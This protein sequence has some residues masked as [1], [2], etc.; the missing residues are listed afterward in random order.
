MRVPFAPPFLAD[1]PQLQFDDTGRPEH[2][3][4]RLRQW[5]ERLLLVRLGP[6]PR[7]CGLTRMCVRWGSP[8]ANET[9]ADVEEEM[10]S[11]ARGHALD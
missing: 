9:V 6:K 2:V 4:D 3:P 5:P 7:R 8:M 11:A 1:V 10:A